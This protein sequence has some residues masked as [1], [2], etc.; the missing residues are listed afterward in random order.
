MAMAT[1]LS[2]RSILERRL[3]DPWL[4][5]CDSQRFWRI[6]G[7]R[8]GELEQY[9][10]P[11]RVL[12]A[13][14]DPVQFLAG[15]FAA[16]ATGHP[17]FLGHAGWSTPEWE[18]AVRVVQPDLVWSKSSSETGYDRSCPDRSPRQ[19][20]WLDEMDAPICIPTG[21][22]SGQLRFVVHTWDTL[23]ASVQGMQAH[24][25]VDAIHSYCVLPVYHVSGLMQAVRSLVTG[26]MLAIASPK[27]LTPIPL[28][29]DPR[30]TFLSLV[31]TQLQRLLAQPNDLRDVAQF[32]AILIGGAPAWPALLNQARQHHLPLAP[33]YGMTEAAS[34]VATLHPEEFLAEAT[35]VGRSLPHV[36]LTVVDSE[37]QR[38]AEGQL[39]R[40][41]I[42]AD[43]LAWGYYPGEPWRSRLFLTDDMGVLDTAGHLCIQGRYSNKIITGGENVYP[44]EVEAAI[45]AT[46]LV[47][48]VCVLGQPD[49]TWGEVVTAIYVPQ[50]EADCEEAIAALLRSQLSPFK[51]PKRWL[52]QS[53][54]PRN[55]QGKLNRVALRQQL[56]PIAEIPATDQILDSPTA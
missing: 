22:T 9:P 14:S 37:E 6:L 35:H 13:D 20:D 29:L 5:G 56:I 51:I 21:G 55:A 18:N 7:Q 46:G 44:N 54:L 34:Q 27:D 16:C 8:I 31:P 2:A 24:F 42:Q 39:G 40:I 25:D 11:T 12:L 32:R 47:R 4:L 48:D 38:L 23:L 26:G 53:S 36:R 50:S 30:N 10:P 28:D 33:T 19:S 1:P 49:T 15:F 43:S 17:L 52:A 3:N 45:L 41:Q